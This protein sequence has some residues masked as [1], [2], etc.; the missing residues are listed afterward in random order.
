[1]ACSLS[2]RNNLEIKTMRRYQPGLVLV[3]GGW[4][5][6]MAGL[7]QAEPQIAGY[8]TRIRGEAVAVVDSNRRPLALGN[9]LYL[10]DQIVTS[11]SALLEARMQDGT[12]V[13]VCPSAEFN[14]LQVQG[15]SQDHQGS[16]FEMV[17]GMFRAVTAPTDAAA[18]PRPPLQVKTPV[19]II[20]VRGTDFWGGFDLLNAGPR[21]LDV[22]MLK[23]TGVY[24]ESEGRR[25]ELRQAGE[26]TTVTGF[27][28]HPSLSMVEEMAM[29][30]AAMP[31]PG[32][33]W[34][35]KKVEAALRTVT[36]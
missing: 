21:T 18:K 29:K 28:A 31:T 9:A 24:V 32:K 14:I 26:G 13:T 15:V 10:G 35:E 25:V 11:H 34:G 1:M 23:G 16:V 3:I 8:V 17:K 27:D 7:A 36:W 5:L 2:L 20:G 19:A 30:S 4:L 33:V 6:I 22:V 12:V